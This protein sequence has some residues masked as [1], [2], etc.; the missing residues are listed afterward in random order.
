MGTVEG[1]AV[2]DGPDHDA[3]PHER[4]DRVDHVLVVPSKAVQPPYDEHVAS[5]ELVEQPLAAFP[6]C[7]ARGDARDAF[8]LDHAVVVDREAGRS[9]LFELMCYGLI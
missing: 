8:V 4:T 1:H 6:L 5:P 2:D 3:A 9:G 7:K